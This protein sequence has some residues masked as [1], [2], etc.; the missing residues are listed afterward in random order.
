MNERIIINLIKDELYRAERN[1]SWEGY[2]V[3]KMALVLA[4]ESGEVCRAVM[5]FEDEG[6]TLEAIEEELIQTAAMCFRMLKNLRNEHQQN[7]PT[8]PKD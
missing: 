1:H 4:E 7:V 3:I 2:G 8:L 5:Q 6:G